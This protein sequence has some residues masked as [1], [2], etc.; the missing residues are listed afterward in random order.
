MSFSDIGKTTVVKKYRFV[1]I[2][3]IKGDAYK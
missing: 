2:L 3:A 1:S